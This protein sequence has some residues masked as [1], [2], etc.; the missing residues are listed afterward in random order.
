MHL[1]H[2][3]GGERCT[4]EL[5]KDFQRAGAE[6]R[7]DAA[8][9][10]RIR[11]R[12]DPVSQQLEF[13]EVLRGE[14]RLLHARELRHLHRRT[15]ERGRQ[16]AIA[17][18]MPAMNARSLFGGVETLEH[19]L[20]REHP[21]IRREHSRIQRREVDDVSHGFAPPFAPHDA[22]VVAVDLREP[23]GEC[24]D[25][26]REHP[27]CDVGMFTQQLIESLTRYE[28]ACHIGRRADRRRSG[29]LGDET[30]LA[31]VLASVQAREL[32]LHVRAG[33]LDDRRCARGDDEETRTRCA[34]GDD[35][36]TRTE[37]SLRACRDKERQ[38][39]AGE[40][41]EDSDAVW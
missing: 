19:T 22:R 41:R 16:L 21:S 36:L 18:R 1:S 11:R 12:C 37:C 26:G 32:D 14:Q 4:T 34:V 7:L 10:E 31:E 24:L 8:G 13:L 28:Q 23:P 20:P 6:L 33:V 39:G 17:P 40:L 35:G 27:A 15:L 30:H 2:R 29:P 25:E 3:R 38:F 5:R 9:N